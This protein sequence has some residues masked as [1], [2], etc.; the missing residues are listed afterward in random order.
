M[1][2]F[3]A[4]PVYDGKLQVQTVKCLLDEAIVANGFGDEIRVTFLPSCSVPAQG[5]NQ[6]VQMFLDSDCDKMFFLD[7]DI[8][9]EPGMIV[10]LGRMPVDFV[11]GCYRFKSPD[12]C[13]PINWMP[14]P[15]LQADE[16]GLLEVAM[17]P[18]GFLCLSRKVFETF[19]EAYPGREYSHWGI[20]SYAFFQMFFKEGA[21]YSD[22]AGF[23]KE[24]LAMG[25]KIHLDPEIALTHWNSMPTPFE[26]HIGNWLKRR[27]G[28][29]LSK[30][31]E[32]KGN[33]NV[34]SVAV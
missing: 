22:D 8:T 25:G 10:K 31:N 27:N 6:L 18:T 1:K 32:N 11:G 3:V 26:G 20:N 4:I 21:L 13:Y 9:F 5:R 15:E 14:N 30:D 17:L 23:C 19:K 28:I 29:P 12:E 2:I 33:N 24:W 16:F 7:A 34:E